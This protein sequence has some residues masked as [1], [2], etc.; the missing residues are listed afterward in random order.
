MQNQGFDLR[1]F[2]DLLNTGETLGQKVYPLRSFEPELSLQLAQPCV[3]SEY[4][5][6]GKF[7]VKYLQKSVWLFV[8]VLNMAC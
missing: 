1:I 4:L 5:M 3:S 2:S 6:K 8:H 7:W